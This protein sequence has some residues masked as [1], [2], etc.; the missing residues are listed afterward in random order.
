MG[1]K[2]EE[3]GPR[4][5]RECYLRGRLGEDIKELEEFLQGKQ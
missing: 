4:L 5:G 3:Q 2:S 1:I